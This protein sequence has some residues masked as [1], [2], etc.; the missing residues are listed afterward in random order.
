MVGSFFV[1]LDLLYPNF[2]LLF[3]LLQHFN[4]FFQILY[5][6]FGFEGTLPLFHMILIFSVI[7]DAIWWEICYLWVSISLILI[8]DVWYSTWRQRFFHVIYFWRTSVWLFTMTP[9]WSLS[10]FIYNFII[11][12]QFVSEF[13]SIGSCQSSRRRFG[14]F[15]M[16]MVGSDLV[17]WSHASIGSVSFVIVENRRWQ[18]RLI[19]LS[20][21]WVILSGPA[22]WLSDS[23]FF[24]IELSRWLRVVLIFI[25]CRVL[26]VLDVSKAWVCLH[27]FSLRR[28]HFLQVSVQQIAWVFVFMMILLERLVFSRLSVVL[29]VDVSLIA[30]TMCFS[31]RII[32]F[33]QL[34]HL[35]RLLLI[36][37]PSLFLGFTSSSVKFGLFSLF[38]SDLFSNRNISSE[39]DGKWITDCHLRYGFSLQRLYMNWQ[40]P[41]SLVSVAQLS[42]CVLTPWVDFATF[43]ESKS[44]RIMRKLADL[45][46]Y[47]V[48][49]L[50]VEP[51]LAFEAAKVTFTPDIDLLVHGY[52]SWKA[53]SNNFLDSTITQVFNSHRLEKLSLFRVLLSPQS[54]L[55][56]GVETS[57]EYFASLRK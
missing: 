48:D 9:T 6:N 1:L 20:H 8:C 2:Q 33:N 22:S 54:K 44:W 40:F 47:D 17:A 55:I 52:S 27:R 26:P 57:T 50:H 18:T 14:E 46:V 35:Y 25:W 24:I 34:I 12:L 5:L 32:N 15:M 4:L 10:E 21:I 37:I 19:W 13:I 11:S 41:A 49:T 38:L 39:H 36:L 3:L 23:I 30:L 56:L 16:L 29:V 45:A 53:T 43:I 31:I 42:E 51:L 7:L 28:L